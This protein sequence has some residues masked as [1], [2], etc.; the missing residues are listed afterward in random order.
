MKRCL[1]YQG[2]FAGRGVKP[3]T[4][5][6]W[7]VEL[8][9]PFEDGTPT[10]TPKQLVFSGDSPLTIEWEDWLPEQAVQGSM[11]TIS[12][13]S[14]KDREF[15]NYYS[16]RAAEIWIKVFRRE[17]GE[18]DYKLIWRG[19]LD[20]EFY[21][22]PYETESGY[23]VTMSFSDFGALE[24][25]DFLPQNMNPDAAYTMTGQMKVTKII[26]SILTSGGLIDT[27]DDFKFT[28]IDDK[29][30][31][32]FP[33]SFLV[34]YNKAG[35]DVSFSFD[36]LLVSTSNFFNEDGEPSTMRDVLEAVL[37]PLSFHIVQR[38][39]R[40]MIYDFGSR[41]GREAPTM[42]NWAGDSQTLSTAETYN[43]VNLRF[44]PYCQADLLNVEI[45]AE[46]EGKE[47]RV[48]PNKFTGDR[49]AGPGAFPS[50]KIW[51][52]LEGEGFSYVYGHYF[53]IEPMMGST[54]ECAGADLGGKSAYKCT[55]EDIP[56]RGVRLPPIYIP[57]CTSYTSK[58]NG[59]RVQIP[60]FKIVFSFDMLF[61]PRPNPFET[62]HPEGDA[63]NG[64]TAYDDFTKY[65]KFVLVPLQ[66]I[67]R[68]Y[69]GEP[70]YYYTN[71]KHFKKETSGQI[72]PFGE[73]ADLERLGEW[74]ALKDESEM[75]RDWA[76]ECFAQFYPDDL[77][78][79]NEGALNGW[80]ANRPI[81]RM[82]D[83]TGK[84]PDIVKKMGDG[85]SIPY[86]PVDGW[87][88]ITIMRAAYVYHHS[89]E[90]MAGDIYNKGLPE[91]GPWD[92][93]PEKGMSM[94]GMDVL[95][96][97]QWWM[98]KSPKVEICKNNIERQN[99]DDD[100]IETV[101]YAENGAAEPLD[102]ETKCGSCKYPSPAQRGL[103]WIGKYPVWLKKDSTENSS[104]YME[105]FLITDIISQY[106]KR[107]A[108]LSGEATESVSNV[109]LFTDHN[110]SGTFI[111]RN[112]MFDA[113][114]GIEDLS[115]VEL[116]PVKY[117]GVEIADL[118]KSTHYSYEEDW[119]PNEQHEPDDTGGSGCDDD[120]RDPDDYD[121]WTD[122]NGWEDW[123][124]DRDDYRDD[125]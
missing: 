18:R 91:H 3:G 10:P 25:I 50:F 105:R 19:S 27:P 76:S 81:I 120:D 88:D 30:R 47:Y 98:I 79:S 23:E 59:E 7:R 45:K 6:C 103:F 12:V 107:R 54:A 16:T 58:L 2:A 55:V 106:S 21:E 13:I 73:Y 26:S 116:M 78:T 113:L 90:A 86:P 11:C 66:I 109:P 125:Y 84:I 63:T 49:W 94:W 102:I 48:I 74:E 1:T 51:E 95:K 110:M 100:D 111:M 20:S 97:I 117:D 60:G 32:F 46:S 121:P 80:T 114:A 22:E 42:I 72:I 5:T 99:P 77:D 61:D 53:K 40:V 65:A 75:P 89:L 82:G 83:G 56:G 124:D 112:S 104:N 123:Y 43:R 87:L 93:G 108:V 36:K 52:G 38:A 34:N 119:R 17:W 28:G 8:W 64:G 96:H 69:K 68:N 39:G 118:S 9:C 29:N 44:S 37:L 4:D 14:M 24:N 31:C 62:A 101:A 57:P 15:I 115:V 85:M 41:F 70:V 122:D 33:E 35:I 92:G 71:A 67:L